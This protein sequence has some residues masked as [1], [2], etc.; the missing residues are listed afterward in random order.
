M[1]LPQGNYLK[2]LSQPCD[3]EGKYKPRH[4]CDVLENDDGKGHNG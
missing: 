4:V 3:N 1:F 2:F